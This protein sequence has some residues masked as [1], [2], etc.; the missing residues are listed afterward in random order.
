MKR[1][2]KP[3][4]TASVLD[5]DH[6]LGRATVDEVDDDDITGLLVAWSE[7]NS[8]AADELVRRLGDR[9][10]R[11]AGSFLRRDRDDHTLQTTDLVHE[12]YLR[13]VD[14]NRVRWQDRDHF[15]AVTGRMMRRILVD[16]ARR[17]AYLKRGGELERVGDDQLEQR[18]APDRDEQLVALDEAL[19]ALEK[20]NR[21]LAAV[22]EL[23]YF[24]GFNGDEIAQSL[25]ISR[26]T[27]Q[28]RWKTAR[29]WLYR[30][31]RNQGSAPPKTA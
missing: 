26:P 29:A 13:L 15:F 6:D 19:D 8:T 14:Q 23:R 1:Q 24:V 3:S 9:L 25:G 10:R 21:G 28:R 31:L 20:E 16:H 12:A 4:D 18:G 2:T 22:V 7:G 5:G 11:L 30:Y 17:R 27:V